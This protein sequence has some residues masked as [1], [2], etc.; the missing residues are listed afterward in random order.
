M[1]D[2]APPRC[3]MRRRRGLAPGARWLEP[4]CIASVRPRR[5]RESITSSSGSA[6]D[7]RRQKGQL[8]TPTQDQAL[9]SLRLGRF[10]ENDTF[11]QKAASMS[12]VGATGQYAV[13]GYGNVTV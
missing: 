5:L 8:M 11:E 1:H 13:P 6:K 3:H 7:L 4:R 2:T 10:S 9:R 12:R